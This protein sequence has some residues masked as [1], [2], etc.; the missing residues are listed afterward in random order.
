MGITHPSVG[1]AG[2]RGLVVMSPQ[3][4]A[5]AKALADEKARAKREKAAKARARKAGSGRN[6]FD[7]STLR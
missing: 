3:Q 5:A 1:L 2:G 7:L 6:S 4:V